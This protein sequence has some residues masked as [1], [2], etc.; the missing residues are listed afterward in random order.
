MYLTLDIGFL[1]A[2]VLWLMIGWKVFKNLPD[3]GNMVA[4]SRYHPRL[5][6]FI[7]LALIFFWPIARVI[8]SVTSAITS[9]M[10]KYKKK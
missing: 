10:D 4:F 1:V 6:P 3:G 2:V 9:N 5:A 8:W 7:V